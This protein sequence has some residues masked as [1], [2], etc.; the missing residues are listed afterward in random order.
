MRVHGLLLPLLCLVSAAP[1]A[2][3]RARL[4]A[5][6]SA[7]IARHLDSLKR[8]VFSPES[9]AVM[10]AR[11]QCPMRVSVEGGAGPMPTGKVDSAVVPEMP[12]YKTNCYNP[13]ADTLAV[14]DR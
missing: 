9:L 10:R 13:L 6:D 1:L 2:G 7:R 3:Q 12:V 5:I 8:T 4:S 11:A 14:K